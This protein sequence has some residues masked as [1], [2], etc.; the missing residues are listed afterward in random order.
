[1]TWMMMYITLFGKKKKT[2]RKCTFICKWRSWECFKVLFCSHQNTKKK[3]KMKWHLIWMKLECYRA[4]LYPP[5]PPNIK[6][7]TWVSGSQY[8][9]N[10][11][12]FRLYTTPNLC[13]VWKLAMNT[14]NC[15]SKLQFMWHKCLTYDML[16]IDIHVQSIFFK[17][18]HLHS[19]LY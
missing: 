16:G 15:L 9:Q 14:M 11:N 10:P 19:I 17:C 2:I 6:A 5:P 13:G 8:V 18:G 7:S 1:M 4:I 3:E 12:I